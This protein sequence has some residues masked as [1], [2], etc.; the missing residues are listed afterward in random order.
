MTDTFLGLGKK[1]VITV[2]FHKDSPKPQWLMLPNILM[3]EP[4]LEY[5]APCHSDHGS[6]GEI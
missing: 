6:S 2:I 3:E 4:H 1:D 5:W